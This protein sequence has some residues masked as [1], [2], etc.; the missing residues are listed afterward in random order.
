ML[1]PYQADFDPVEPLRE[2]LESAPH[3]DTLSCFC[4]LID[5]TSVHFCVFLLRNILNTHWSQ[6]CVLTLFFSSFIIHFTVSQTHYS[7][8]N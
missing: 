7:F 6:H 8:N 2:I 5:H 4:P 3:R 1:Y